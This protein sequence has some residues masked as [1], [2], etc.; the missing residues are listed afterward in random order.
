[1]EKTYLVRRHFPDHP[2]PALF[3]F[4]QGTELRAEIAAMRTYSPSVDISVWLI[5]K[6]PTEDEINNFR[7]EQ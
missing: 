7:V 3:E 5:S 2:S 1:M 4:V 6:R